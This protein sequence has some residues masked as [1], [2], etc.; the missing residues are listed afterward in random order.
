MK[1]KS[2]YALLDW[3]PSVFLKYETTDKNLSPDGQYVPRILFI[4]EYLKHQSLSEVKAPAVPCISNP[5]PY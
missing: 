2:I 1:E 5:Q 4:G 3:E